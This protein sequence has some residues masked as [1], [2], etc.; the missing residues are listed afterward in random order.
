M[1]CRKRSNDPVLQGT[2]QVQQDNHDDRD[3]RQP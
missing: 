2:D 3:A 1:T